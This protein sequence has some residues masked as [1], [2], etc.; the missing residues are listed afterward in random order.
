[1]TLKLT[2]VIIAALGALAILAMPSSALAKAD[3]NKDGIPDKW[4]KK[5][6]LSLKANQKNKDQDRD[7][8]KN[9]NEFRSGTS[10]VAADTD[11][12][13]VSDADEDRDRDGVD[14]G[15]EETEKTRVDDRDSDNNG[16]L[17]GSEDADSDGLT[18]SGE[19]VS[20]NDPVDEDTDN[21]GLLD[22]EENAGVVSSFDPD[23]GLLVIALGD[24]TELSGTVDGTT[25]IY[26]E[27]EDS[28]EIENESDERVFRD[29]DD[30]TEDSEEAESEDEVCA[31]DL[32]VQGARIHEA[33][34]DAV[35]GVFVSVEI[36]SPDHGDDHG[37]ESAF[38]GAIDSYNAE[39]GELVVAVGDNGT[40]V[41][42][43]SVATRIFCKPPKSSRK[44]GENSVVSCAVDELVPGTRVHKAK[45]KKGGVYSKIMLAKSVV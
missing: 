34:L 22:G 11:T 21:D 15:N 5:Y 14:N 12:D 40:R 9:I 27:D 18:N 36:V 30:E 3:K 42:T 29:G 45:I 1:M 43:V 25:A 6:G 37:K 38:S 35:T 2:T 31:V 32:L 7:G 16:T 28:H 23:T 44:D 26:C 10:P 8:L 41:G 24:G 19:D 13:G 20:G 33:S 4:E 17:D 39:T